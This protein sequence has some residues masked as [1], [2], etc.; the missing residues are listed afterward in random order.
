MDCW[1]VKTKGGGNLVAKDIDVWS[2]I[3]D[4]LENGDIAED[5]EGDVAALARVRWVTR[6]VRA[7]F[8]ECNEQIINAKM[9]D[10]MLSKIENWK[11]KSSPFGAGHF[12]F[13]FILFL[14]YFILF[15]HSV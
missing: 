8:D 15:L 10:E 11:P 12:W 13:Y 9:I 6:M 7:A 4:I 2:H 5:Y 1:K 3:L 14:L